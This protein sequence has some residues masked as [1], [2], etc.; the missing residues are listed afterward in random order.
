MRTEEESL[1]NPMNTPTRSLPTTD[2]NHWKALSY[3][4]K[5]AEFRELTASPYWTLLPE[6]IK[7]RIRGLLDC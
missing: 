2:L 1:M 4:E 5:L 6:T 7:I 3:E